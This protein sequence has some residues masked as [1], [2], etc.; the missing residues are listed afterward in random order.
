MRSIFP[1]LVL[2][3]LTGTNA[4]AMQNWKQTKMLWAHYVA[5][6][7][8][9]V[10]GFDNIANAPE[11]IANPFTDR[12][13]DHKNLQDDAGTWEG[14]HSQIR[15]AIQFGF[16]GFCVDA[17]RQFTSVLSRFYREAEGTPFKIAL[18]VDGN[19]DHDSLF[20]ELKTFITTY[21]D[22]PNACLIDNKLVIFV[23]TL[24]IP[25]E[26]WKSVL[27]K[28]DEINLKPYILAKPIHES[29]NWTQTQP[30]E[31]TLEIFDGIYDFG[32]NGFTLQEQFIRYE[33]TRTA[34]K[35]ARPDAILV[36]G[37]T[38]G[39]IGHNSGFYRPFLNS[40]T[41]RDNWNAA[42]KTNAEWV[43]ITTWNDYGEH[44]QFEPSSVNRTALL[45]IN[46]AY[47]DIWRETAT[48]PRPPQPI[49]TYRDELLL[50]TDFT[51]DAVIPSF[52]TQPAT[53]TL[54]LKDLDGKTIKE[55]PPLELDG[56]ET[57]AHT[58]RINAID[59]FNWLDAFTVHATLTDHLNP[60]KPIN[61]QLPPV[62][63]RYAK[64]ENLRPVRVA[65]DEISYV[66]PQLKLATKEGAL[67]ALVT[68]ET[69]CHAGTV[70]ILRNGFPV[71]TRDFQLLKAPRHT[72]EIPLPTQRHAQIDFYVAR[73]TGTANK[74]AWSNPVLNYEDQDPE[75]IPQPVIVHTGDLDE[76]WPI[77]STPQT[78]SNEVDVNV[79]NLNKNQILTLS[80]DFAKHPKNQRFF[81]SSTHQTPIKIG[82]T[83][84]KWWLND[85]KNNPKQITQTL[86]DGT[87]TNVLEFDGIDDILALPTRA[88]PYG[89]YVI[90]CVLKPQRTDAKQVIFADLNGTAEIALD[91]QLNLT[92]T[93]LKD[94]PVAT[95]TP[96]V[97]DTWYHIAAIYDSK[98]MAIAIN[99]AIVASAPVSPTTRYINSAPVF[100]H[101]GNFQSC[102]KGSI[103]AFQIKAGKHTQFDLLPQM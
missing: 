13:L 85:P 55:F 11:G 76:I 47:A 84:Q 59:T 87:E 44:T 46:Q 33:N 90:E 99:G 79:L 17:F 39:Y 91:P 54:I 69:W 66:T 51:I 86:P 75:T 2:F 45:K 74:N 26:T 49:F 97:P 73:T 93:R 61:R 81:L 12:S 58:W 70:E 71:A 14:I 1:F 53:L 83:P 23:Y 94:T 67:V 43:C 9:H 31:K 24:A 100:G 72:L 98:Q 63:I 15:T 60:Q 34:I 77:W 30:I 41:T 29:R 89:P 95:P 68:M 8:D 19:L 35:N 5:W 103:K 38:P 4:F 32:C 88:M 56:K 27:A 21:K 10:N 37:V 101:D 62:V 20:E 3:I 96:L 64:L 50:G 22:H 92:F 36:A 78:R 18:C 82:A 57:F 102:F 40:K 48:P 25:H 28:L 16:D 65:W 52:T 6:G 7:F 80:Y 42:I